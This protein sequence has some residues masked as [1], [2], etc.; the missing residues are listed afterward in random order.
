M[1]E[2]FKGYK[3][4]MLNDSVSNSIKN[5]FTDLFG[6]SPSS[7]S[8]PESI[9]KAKDQNTIKFEIV[10][11]AIST[12]T[13]PAGAMIPLALHDKLLHDVVWR[14]EFAVFLTTLGMTKPV[15]CVADL[16]ADDA[17]VSLNIPSLSEFYKRT[18]GIL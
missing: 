4:T 7:G 10:N 17:P 9:K 8:E 12:T 11:H 15:Y 13:L 1:T 2:L 16:V 5:D 3:V 14:A 18:R 6:E